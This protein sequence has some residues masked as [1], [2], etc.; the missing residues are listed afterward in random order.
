MAA[1]CLC[2][3]ALGG[4]RV[5]RLDG[6]QGGGLYPSSDRL[7]GLWGEHRV[8][9]HPRRGGASGA[10][11]HGDDRAVGRRDLSGQCEADAGL[12]LGCSGRLHHAGHRAGQPNGP[13]R[14]HQPSF[15]SRADQGEPVPGGRLHGLFDGHH[16]NRADGRDRADHARDHGRLRL[17]GTGVDR[18]PRHGRFRVEM[19]PDL[20]CGRAGPLVAGRGDRLLLGPGN[21]LCGPGGRGRL[22]PRAQ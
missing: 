7:L 2:V 15:Q 20:R 17:G 16:T 21:D 11:G 18:S 14:R 3:R 22:V 19:V 9:R 4:D 1:E 6:D 5:H 8:R 10:G 13:D 12:F